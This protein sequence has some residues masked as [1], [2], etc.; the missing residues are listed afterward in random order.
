MTA[1]HAPILARPAAEIRRLR[2][3]LDDSQQ[4]LAQ[5]RA[6]IVA[7][8]RTGDVEHWRSLF[9]DSHRADLENAYR[10]GYDQAEADMAASWARNAE[11]VVHPE[12]AA[13]RRLR[14]AEAGCRR[15]A[16]DH[17]RAF[18]ARAHNTADRDRT[19][20]QRA[21]VH[22]YPRKTGAA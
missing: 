4:Q 9:A 22:L 19:D 15:D 20:A 1:G 5:L 21:T 13:E 14:A 12:R 8:D 3:Q 17:E 2:A 11:R 7:P 10:A 6:L 18:I 16:A